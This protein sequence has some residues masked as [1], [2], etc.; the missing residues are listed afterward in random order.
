MKSSQHRCPRKLKFGHTLLKRY[1]K[2]ICESLANNLIEKV[3]HNFTFVW[4]SSSWWKFERTN[5]ISNHTLYIIRGCGQ[6]RANISKARCPEWPTRF[7][8]SSSQRR[9]HL[10]PRSRCT[11]SC[12]KCTRG[13][14][15]GAG[16]RRGR[17]SSSWCNRW[18]TDS[19]KC[20]TCL[21]GTWKVFISRK[22]YA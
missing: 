7:A 2:W 19:S 4:I 15:W 13:R 14:W 21:R 3:L 11:C 8:Q 12:C 22:F 1:Y 9:W 16:G 18:S 6:A 20:W 17:R 5:K 10:Q